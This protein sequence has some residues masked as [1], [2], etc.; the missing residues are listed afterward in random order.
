MKKLFFSL[1]LISVL[2]LPAISR[3]GD[4]IIPDVPKT[5]IADTMDK[6][7]NILFYMLMIGAFVCILISAFQFLTAAGDPEKVGTARNYIIYALIAIVV[8]VL[9]KGIVSFVVKGLISSQ[10]S[11][12]PD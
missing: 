4:D 12:I 6:V 8:G 9:A 5:S 2:I 11:P 3:G 1:I 10:S 7:G